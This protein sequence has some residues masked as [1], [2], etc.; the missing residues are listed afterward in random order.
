MLSPGGEDTEQEPG[1]NEIDL[2]QLKE[3]HLWQRCEVEIDIER[4][5]HAEFSEDGGAPR[6]LQHEFSKE[7]FDEVLDSPL[8]FQSPLEVYV[9]PVADIPGTRSKVF[10][11]EAT[12]KDKRVR[13][14]VFCHQHRFEALL[15]V[16]KW[17]NR[18]SQQWKAT[19]TVMCH[20]WVGLETENM[21]LVGNIHNDIM[22][23]IRK[24][25]NEEFI[26]GL[27]REVVRCGSLV[28]TN[29]NDK[30]FNEM[31]RR[32]FEVMN[33][34]NPKQFN[35]FYYQWHVAILPQGVFNQ[36]LNVMNMHSLGQLKGMHAIAPAVTSSQV[37]GTGQ[38]GQMAT[39]A[40]IVRALQEKKKKQIS[41]DFYQRLCW[42][43]SESDFEKVQDI[44]KQLIDGL[45]DMNE[46]KTQLSK[47]HEMKKLQIQVTFVSNQD[48]WKDFQAKFPDHANYHCMEKLR[49]SLPR[50]SGG[51]GKGGQ[52]WYS[53]VKKGTPHPFISQF[54]MEAQQA[55]ELKEKAQAGQQ[56]IM[57]A[58]NMQTV[59]FTRDHNPP[60]YN[61]NEDSETDKSLLLYWQVGFC[62]NFIFVALL[63]NRWSSQVDHK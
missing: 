6:D 44:L 20:I 26:K 14:V 21:K 62:M 32:C 50:L 37:K 55:L 29:Q 15:M 18:D 52:G 63:Y 48:T 43:K 47:Y 27:H 38:A 49:L 23:N 19:C 39:K 41:N 3:D 42:P 36:L 10:F 60:W 30:E 58:K 17:A 40:P 8:L 51:K 22:H 2:A 5:T 59:T 12:L 9:V 61:L 13:F 54:L 31:K 35:K 57:S 25:D 34:K 24:R 4:I 56:D 46:C 53:D 28:A 16:H 7:I 33:V 45:L 11:T 1:E